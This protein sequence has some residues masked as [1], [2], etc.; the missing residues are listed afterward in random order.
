MNLKDFLEKKE[1]PPELLW[2]IVIEEG[3]VQAGI[4]YI[5]E[6]AAEVISISSVAPWEEDEDLVGAVDTTLSSSVQKLPEE[7]SEPNKTVFGVSSVWVKGGEIA[8]E[9]LAKIKKV[10][11]E[12]SLTPVGFVVL[13]EAIAHLYKSEEGAPVSAIILGLGTEFLEISVFKLGNLVGTTSVARSISLVEDVTEGLSRFEGATPLPSR[14]IL[15]DGKEAQLEEAKESLIQA[16]WNENE[17]VKFLHTP[18][19]EILNSD[20]KVLAV[21]LAGA[22]EIGNVA[23]VVSQ[24]VSSPNELEDASFV[25]TP[26]NEEPE[27]LSEETENVQPVEEDKTTAEDLGFVIGEDVSTTVNP[28]PI[29]SPIA[30]QVMPHS[31]KIDINP[32]QKA[33]DIYKKTKNIFHNFSNKYFS[34]K[35]H[36]SLQTNKKPVAVFLSLLAVLLIGLGF[37]WWFY[38]KAD[39]LIYVTPKK[40][41]QETQV[42]FNTNGQF[43]AASG[44][45]PATALTTKVS[46][47]KTKATTGTKTIGDKA[48]GTVQIQ[49]G[50]AFP[51]NLTAGTFL[52]S[53]G[54]LKF[55]LD[56]SASVSAALSPSSPGTATINVTA[57][58]IG[59]EYNLAKDEIYKVGNYPKAEVDAIATADFSGGNSTQISAVSKDDQTSLESDL[60]TELSQ[61]AVDQL[62]QKLTDNQIFVGDLA[63]LTTA[64]EVFDHKVGDQAD[65]IKLSL[66]LETTGVAADREKLLEYARGVLKDKIPSGF[67]LRD[68]QIN[69]KF[70]FVDQKDGSFNYKMTISANFLPNVNTDS[71]IKQIAGKTPEV[72]ETYLSKVPGFSRASVTLKPR[73]P[74]F[75]GTLP[76]V[77]KNIT[78]EVSAEQ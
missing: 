16:E 71:I 8:E 44:I 25:E 67:V 66:S 61:N 15:F 60:K 39:V 58:S 63:L 9:Y 30:T 24:D 46:G 74:G 10:C 26:I 17:K 70:V 57:D 31:P 4:W 35:P 59:A 37:L 49:N 36:V 75:L 38:P 52:A 78:I 12:L 64:S 18:K 68:S 69:F 3:W 34:N 51:I 22:N 77:A 48:K 72:V 53:S 65:K 5:G 54:N 14:F 28:M 73:L 40:F 29:A 1:K 55:S 76:R 56:T 19:V 41:E 11:T 47:E 50:T 21:S 2:S 33:E 23:Q 43:D 13:P 42:S 62:S 20:K 32:Q 45:V 27:I 7:Y 6:K